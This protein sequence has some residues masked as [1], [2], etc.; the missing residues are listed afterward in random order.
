[1]TSGLS[2]AGRSG[3]PTVGAGIPKGL[4]DLA[5]SKGADRDELFRRAGL[6]PADFEDQD[7]RIAMPDYIALMRA[8]K[9]LAND[10]AIALHYGESVDLSEVSITGLLAN[11]S[12]TMGEAMVQLNRFG[13]L[14][15][16]VE[17]VGPGEPRFESVFKDGGVW[18]MDRRTN[19]NV[20]PELT[21][22]T[23]AR[24]T[25][26]R[27]FLPR[28]HILEVHVTHSDPG[29][30]AEYDRIFQCPVKFSTEWNAVRVD[31]ELATHRVRLQPQY[32]FGVLSERAEQLLKDLEQSKTDRGRVEA[33]LLPILHT[34]EISMDTIAGKMGISRQT[35][36]RRLK[37]EGV[38]YEQVLDELRHRLA[39]HY[40]DGKKVSVNEAGYLVGFSEP[41]A[42]SR[43]FK[44]WTGKSPRNRD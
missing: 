37:E 40:L 30:R 41:S 5:V 17:G 32:V 35:L 25:H 26:P 14:A 21:E 33:L 9:E 16:E 23:F 7:N 1:M 29:Y 36:F 42:F 28:P 8:A 18:V 13:R 11:A 22:V 3:G 4:M 19:P 44:R 31:P 12:E 34:G 24:L 20:F 10:Q 39:L 38:T 43:A 6:T 15:I 27:R 2:E